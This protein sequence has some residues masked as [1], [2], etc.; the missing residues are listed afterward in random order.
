MRIIEI[1]LFVFFNI[2]LVNAYPAI[3][4]V[5]SFIL[6]YLSAILVACITEGSVVL[7]SIMFWDS[8][9]RK[10]LWPEYYDYDY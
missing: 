10:Y 5:E 1:G 8:V 6:Y 7:L 3:W 9:L 4:T 2:K